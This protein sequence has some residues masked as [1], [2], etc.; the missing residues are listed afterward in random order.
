MTSL[1]ELKIMNLVFILFY[2]LLG[3]I[4]NHKIKKTKHDTVTGHMTRLHK[5]HAHMTRWNNVEGSRRR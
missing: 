2:F 1:S 4:V 5:S 3:F